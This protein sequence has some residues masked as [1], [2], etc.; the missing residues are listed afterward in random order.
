MNHAMIEK[1]TT[2]Q[3]ATANAAADWLIDAVACATQDRRFVRGDDAY[4][5]VI[6]EAIIANGKIACL[7]AMHNANTVNKDLIAASEVM[8]DTSGYNQKAHQQQVTS[9]QWSAWCKQLKEAKRFVCTTR[10]PLSEAIRCHCCGKFT[11]IAKSVQSNN[12]LYCLNC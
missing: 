5:E 12:K 10:T 3:I 9:T 4:D 6:S 2:E 11:P 1:S 7:Q 8:R